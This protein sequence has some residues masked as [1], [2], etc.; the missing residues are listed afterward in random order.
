MQRLHLVVASQLATD[1]GKIQGNIV[2]IDTAWIIR[3][4]CSTQV[5]A[6]CNIKVAV[7]Q[8]IAAAADSQ[9]ALGL[10][11]AL[12]IV[13]IQQVGTTAHIRAISFFHC[14]DSDIAGFGSCSL[15][16]ISMSHALR[17][18]CLIFICNLFLIRCQGIKIAIV[19]TE[20]NNTIGSFSLLAQGN[21][22]TIDS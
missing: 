22:L 17:G 13:T 3:D 19:N 21:Q 6:A 5:N 16:L 12:F 9:V 15:Q 10:K 8:N 20:N 11:L 2:D 1:I 7:D 18:H 4:F 14:T